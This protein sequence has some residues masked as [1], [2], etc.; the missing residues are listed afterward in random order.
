MVSLLTALKP[1]GMFVI[2]LP[3]TKHFMMLRAAL[4]L[5]LCIRFAMVTEIVRCIGFAG[6]GLSLCLLAFLPE[7]VRQLCPYAYLIV[8]ACGFASMYLFFYQADE[9]GKKLSTG[10]SS[11]ILFVAPYAAFPVWY[12][13]IVGIDVL[14]FIITS[15]RPSLLYV[16]FIT[17]AVILLICILT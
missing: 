2:P 1:L 17:T 14:T 6:F 4:S 12:F 13:V 15:R 5:S 7:P 3:D 8:F 11:L 16:Q 10:I 9:K